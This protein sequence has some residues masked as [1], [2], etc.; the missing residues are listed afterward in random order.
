[1]SENSNYRIIETLASGGTAVLYKAVQ[2]S[3]DRVVAVKRL[4]QHLTTDENFTRRFELEAKAAASLDHEN[5]VRVI[6]F[7]VESD[8][9]QMVM[10]LIEGESL[11][12]ILERWHP[13]NHDLALAIV[14]QICRGLEHAHAK[15]IVHRDIKPGNVMVTRAGAVKIA[16][17]GLA[18]L[19]QGNT[20]QTAAESI[21]GTPL[22]MSPEQA[23]G[24]NVDQRSDLFSLGTVLYEMLTGTQPFAGENYMG[25]IQNILKKE[26]AGVADLNPNVPREVEEIVGHALARDREERFQSARAF[27][28]S[29]EQLLGI[30][31]LSR[32]LGMIPVL[33]ERNSDTRVVSSREVRAQANER[34][35]H[36]APSSAMKR[37]HKAP[38]S[39]MKRSRRAPSSARKK[40]RRGG[41]VWPGVT[42]T[43]VA[44]AATGY[45]FLAG[46]GR[47]SVALPGVVTHLQQSAFSDMWSA[48]ASLD[49]TIPMDSTLFDEAPMDTVTTAVPD[50][51]TLE[52]EKVV[53]VAAPETTV[54][55]KPA[56]VRNASMPWVDPKTVAKQ[57]AP[58]PEPEPVQT[59][60]AETRPTAKP[61]A[62]EEPE[63][64]REGY[65][66]ITMEP[67]GQ[68]YVNGVYR[69][70]ANPKLRLTLNAGMNNIE[71]RA[72]Q[73]DRYQ[74]S[75]RIIAGETSSRTVIL[76]KFKGTISL[77]TQ[78][79]AE[80]YV[81][82]NL[83]GVTPLLRPIEV[84][85]GRHT[86]TIKKAN[87]Y[88]W[89]SEVT[90][91]PNATLP[92][93][94]TLSPRY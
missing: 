86:L 69:G 75:L 13:I 79:G 74:E 4:H 72:D 89:T 25:V 38:S 39:A 67:E 20:V 62:E 78:E 73:H 63:R 18:K 77:A 57:S 40:K 58:E 1:V 31:G 48:D 85:A 45:Y 33:L 92:L 50:P 56:P 53:A 36:K 51:E 94:I 23:F 8:N 61:V 76:H 11:R 15:G 2:I 65:L 22:Y 64:F 19:T 66:M 14:H 71:C 60:P 83:I 3:L 70:L 49:P 84:D 43:L 68:V 28:E 88:T 16:D 46:P 27:R 82:G 47:G 93:R 17:F 54:A 26:V 37:S 35:T 52:A 7:G 44:L 5:I 29:I 80:F 10:E 41:R 90:V 81:D 34:V 21:L 30:E 59:T 32:S 55:P 24:E 91:E 6:D 42:L 9:Y 87:H 12:E